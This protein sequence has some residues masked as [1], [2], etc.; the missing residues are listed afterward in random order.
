MAVLMARP[1]FMAATVDFINTVVR[2]GFVAMF[3]PALPDGLAL[4]AGGRVSFRTLATGQSSVHGLL[5]VR[6]GMLEVACRL[7]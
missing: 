3:D 5:F 7:R 6:I 4:K 1:A 2:G